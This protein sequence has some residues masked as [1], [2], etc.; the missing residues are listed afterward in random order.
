MAA[1]GAIP[2][3]A[4]SGFTVLGELGLDG[5]VA[6]VTG[7]LPAAIGAN[8]RAEGLICPAGCG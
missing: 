1:I 5:S 7:V 6:P 3:D 8:G 4:M 2:A